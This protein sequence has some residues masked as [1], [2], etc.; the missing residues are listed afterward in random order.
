[1]NSDSQR[2]SKSLTLYTEPASLHDGGQ[3]GLSIRSIPLRSYFATVP[4]APFCIT[5]VLFQSVIFL[6]QLLWE[7]KFSAPRPN[8]LVAGLY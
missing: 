5:D 6:T 8:D 2:L 4:T 7:F 3:L 1:M